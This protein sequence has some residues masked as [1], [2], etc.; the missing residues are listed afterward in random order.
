MFCSHDVRSQRSPQIFFLSILL[1]HGF[2]LFSHLT[3]FRLRLQILPIQSRSI[4][5]A[6]VYA[7]GGRYDIV[8][9]V[10]EFFAG[11]LALGAKAF[12]GS[13][14]N[15]SACLYRKVW[16]AFDAGD[17]ATVAL[18]MRKICRGVDLLNAN[19]GIPAGK[20]MMLVK[21]VD[22]GKARLPLRQLSA[23]ERRGIADAMRKIIGE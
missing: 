21:D 9:G 18:N 10:D 4:G 17:W 23:A 20:A 6:E 19:G 15:Y 13:T 5:T 12:I 16:Q 22:C 2:Q 7:C 3:I 1:T 14:Y 8:F 11:A